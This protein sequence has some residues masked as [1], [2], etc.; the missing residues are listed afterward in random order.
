[1]PMK[2]SWRGLV[3]STLSSKTQL[4]SLW[5]LGWCGCYY[6]SYTYQTCWS[7][8]LFAT[9]TR[10]IFDDM[11]SSLLMLSTMKENSSRRMAS[12]FW[13]KMQIFWLRCLQTLG[14][15]KIYEM[16]RVL[17]ELP[18]DS[19]VW[20]VLSGSD[21]TCFGL[22]SDRGCNLDL[23]LEPDSMGFLGANQSYCYLTTYILWNKK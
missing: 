11:S 5:D 4:F 16:L 14:I 9:K 6:R 2:T 17:R 1:M 12:G 21:L 13:H 19:S 22:K 23:A 7:C 3:S 18:A 20:T 8:G 15:G 10:E